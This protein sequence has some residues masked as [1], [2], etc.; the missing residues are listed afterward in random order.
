MKKRNCM[1]G[2]ADSVSFSYIPVHMCQYVSGSSSYEMKWLH[3]DH[4]LWNQCQSLQWKMLLNVYVYIYWRTILYSWRGNL[5]CNK[6]EHS[7]SSTSL[8]KVSACSTPEIPYPPSPSAL[9]DFMF[10]KQLLQS[11]NFKKETMFSAW[12]I[13]LRHK[14]AHNKDI[15]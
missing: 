13:P 9:L 15:P 4:P 12:R 8:Y 10:P 3:I 11:R 5:E 7:M 2:Y 6:F 1:F 14:H